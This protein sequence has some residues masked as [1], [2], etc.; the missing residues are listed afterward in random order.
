[1]GLNHRVR[2]STPCSSTTDQAT[3]W[4]ASPLEWTKIFQMKKPNTIF[5]SCSCKYFES[6]NERVAKHILVDL[7][8]AAI[9]H[10]NNHS[11]RSQDSNHSNSTTVEVNTP[12]RH[13]GELCSTTF[14]W[15]WTSHWQAE[16]TAGGILSLLEWR[17]WWWGWHGLT[18]SFPLDTDRLSKG[19][20]LWLQ[21]S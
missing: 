10:H 15:P 2:T 17:K 14:L 5:F 9:S 6:S 11:H 16:K 18:A 12:E 21:R 1:M 8:F 3:L 19:C 7:L 13:T 20:G 4:H